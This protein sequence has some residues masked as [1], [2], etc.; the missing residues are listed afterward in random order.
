MYVAQVLYDAAVIYY[1]YETGVQVFDQIV[2]VWAAISNYSRR[3]TDTESYEIDKESLSRPNSRHGVLAANAEP[4]VGAV[5]DGEMPK[6]K[7]MKNERRM[8]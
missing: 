3:I 6:Q 7:K 4:A 1:I 5:A 8:M 2:W